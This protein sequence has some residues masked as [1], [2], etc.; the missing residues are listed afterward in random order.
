MKPEEIRNI[1]IEAIQDVLESRESTIQVTAESAIM[2]EGGVLDSMGLVT[3]I[4]DI[5]SKFNESG[6]E[7]SLTNEKAMSKSSSPFISIASLTEYIIEILNE[8]N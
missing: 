4:I 6:T 1:I 8:D 2:G 5:E 7:I 3:A